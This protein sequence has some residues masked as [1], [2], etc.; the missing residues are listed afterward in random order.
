MPVVPERRKVPALPVRQW[1]PEWEEVA[2]SSS[3]FRGRPPEFFYM[4][5]MDA[6]ELKA[7]TGVTRRS[8]SSGQARAH[9]PGIQRRHEVPRSRE[10][11]E[12]VRH[13][14]PWS[15]LSKER[16][17]SAEFDDLKKPGWL[18]TAIVV[19]ILRP[20]DTAEGSSVHRQDVV[21]VVDPK[22]G[23]IAELLLP[24]GFTGRGW[25]PRAKGAHP[26]SVID[27]QHRLWAFEDSDITGFELPVVAFVG[28]DI[29]WQA[30]LFYTIN[31]KPKKINPSLAFDLYP[32]LRT[33]DWLDRFEGHSVYRETRAQELTE[34]LWAYPQSPWHR[35]IN[36]VGESGTR[37]VTQNSWIR[38]LLATFVKASA[39]K[40]VSIGGLYGAK[41]GS[42]HLAI[43]WNRAQQAAFLVFAWR[44]LAEAIEASDAEWVASLREEAGDAPLD[45]G[46]AGRFSLLNNDQGVRGFLSVL[47]DLC[48][49]S[50]DRLRLSEWRSEEFSDALSESAISAAL[51]DLESLPAAKFV[52]LIASDLAR[53]D[54]RSSAAPGLGED[55][56]REKSRFRGSTGYR[57]I[58]EELV[59][60]LCK[61]TRKQVTAAA[62]QVAEA[63]ARD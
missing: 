14:F 31:I 43:P 39:G 29:A 54:W 61:S 56:R 23:G 53:F 47:N 51:D 49:V 55:L 15:A 40:G 18:P 37:Q 28:L 16:K 63:I 48:V 57:E 8:A 4:F 59:G 7:L 41:V 46:V 36:M 1:L 5:K 62:I 3:D 44:A 33:A 12:Y 13:G 24:P 60:F 19:N 10:I 42:D 38:S 32:L 34:A 21:D 45:A 17:E 50:A 22:D 26:I 25:Q 11:G 58:R 30:Y 6:V 20:E 35:R 9:D 27:G 2:F 52:S